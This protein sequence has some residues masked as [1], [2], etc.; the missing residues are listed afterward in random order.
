MKI[1]ISHQRQWEITVTYPCKAHSTTACYLSP[2]RR[3]NLLARPRLLIRDP[4]SLTTCTL[5]F[6]AWLP[7]QT[8]HTAPSLPTPTCPSALAHAGPLSGASVAAPSQP[9]APTCFSPAP[10]AGFRSGAGAFHSAHG[11]PAAPS[12]GTAADVPAVAGEEV[13]EVSDTERK[14]S[15]LQS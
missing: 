3:N 11:S 15:V 8:A 7:A 9:P 4:F 1:L 12:S 6:S 14:G 5:S 13:E 2:S 10:P